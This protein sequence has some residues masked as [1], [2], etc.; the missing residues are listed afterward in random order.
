LGLSDLT[1]TEKP[2]PGL[3]GLLS[4]IACIGDALPAERYTAIF[5]QAGFGIQC[6]EDHGDALLEM[7]LQVQGRLLGAEV[8]TALKKINLRGVDFATGRQF[9]QAALRAV[10]DGSLGYAAVLARK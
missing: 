7:V 3:E 8:M 6:V 4:W 1:R 9:A 5:E 10:R 2:I